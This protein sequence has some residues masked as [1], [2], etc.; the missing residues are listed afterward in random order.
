[1][2][3]HRRCEICNIN[4]AW[5]TGKNLRFTAFPLNLDRCREWLKRVGN[6]ELVHLPVEKLHERRRVCSNHFKREDYNKVGNRLNRNA[7]PSLNLTAPPLTDEQLAAFPQH[8]YR[9]SDSHEHSPVSDQRQD[10]KEQQDDLPLVV[11]PVPSTSKNPTHIDFDLTQIGIF[12]YLLALRR[13]IARASSLP[14]N[15]YQN[16]EVFLFES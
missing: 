15:C 16:I 14:I 13:V 6:D 3:G 1:M 10:I 12:I 5:P 11:Q 7:I 9:R 2:G 8:V 4:E